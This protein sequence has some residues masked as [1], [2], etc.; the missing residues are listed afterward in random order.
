LTSANYVGC[1]TAVNEGHHPLIEDKPD[2]SKFTSLNKI[3]TLQVTIT[4]DINSDATFL[5]SHYYLTTYSL[6]YCFLLGQELLIKYLTVH[7]STMKTLLFLF[8]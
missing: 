8:H 6:L 5:P 4:D 3:G 2:N 7:I 1:V